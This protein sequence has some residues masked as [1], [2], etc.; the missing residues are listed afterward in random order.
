MNTS[1][2]NTRDGPS[3]CRSRKGPEASEI[4]LVPGLG[5]EMSLERANLPAAE[6]AEMSE[7]VASGTQSHVEDGQGWDRHIGHST[8]S[9][10]E[11][12]EQ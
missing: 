10:S 3:K 7:A 11:P 2:V 4:W 6:E 12:R 5:Q 9:M 8:A 1:A